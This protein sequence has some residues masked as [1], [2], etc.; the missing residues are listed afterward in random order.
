MYI[1]LVNEGGQ[2]HFKNFKDDKFEYA[3]AHRNIDDDV[4]NGFKTSN[5]L[6]NDANRHE[7]SSEE[8]NEFESSIYSLLENNEE[9]H[10]TSNESVSNSEESESLLNTT[11]QD[12]QQTN[13]FESEEDIKDDFSEESPFTSNEIEKTHDNNKTSDNP[14]RDAYFPQVDEDDE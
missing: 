2:I 7:N 1:E 13:N 8:Y 12:P 3:N 14:L 10:V 4:D 5:L 6:G 9:N 11:N